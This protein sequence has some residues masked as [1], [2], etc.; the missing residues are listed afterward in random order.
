MKEKKVQMLMLKVEMRDVDGN[1]LMKNF[2][3]VIILLTIPSHLEVDLENASIKS[4]LGQLIYR[5]KFIL[6]AFIVY[7]QW[8]NSL[9]YKLLDFYVYLPLAG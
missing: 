6:L 4:L 5:F 2:W 8:L 9:K 7:L 3:L 1:T